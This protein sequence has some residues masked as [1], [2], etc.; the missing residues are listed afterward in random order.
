MLRDTGLMG[1]TSGIIPYKFVNLLSVDGIV[2]VYGLI[3][4]STKS[5]QFKASK[6]PVWLFL[7]IVV[8]SSLALLTVQLVFGIYQVDSVWELWITKVSDHD[9]K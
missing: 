4:S 9:C 1:W 3:K 2:V 7:L 8:F 6:W 5:S